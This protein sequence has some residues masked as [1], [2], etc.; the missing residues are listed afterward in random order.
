MTGNRSA[1]LSS[2]MFWSS[3]RASEFGSWTASTT[4]SA[5]WLAAGG[6]MVRSHLRIVG[7]G[8]VI[9]IVATPLNAPGG[10]STRY[11]P[12]ATLP[13]TAPSMAC[14]AV[15]GTPTFTVEPSTRG[16]ASKTGCGAAALG[17]LVAS[18]ADF[19]QPESAS[20]ATAAARRRM[21][22][23]T[24]M[25]TLLEPVAGPFPPAGPATRD[26]QEDACPWRVVTAPRMPGKPGRQYFYC[27]LPRN[28]LRRFW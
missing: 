21:V 23:G 19:E 1:N 17:A 14:E 11:G 8:C 27:S 20:T 26:A 10:T 24:D 2:H 9:V 28:A 22:R 7:S 15:S 25:T 16:A 4:G 12:T 6:S 3:V 5:N 18:S 13:P